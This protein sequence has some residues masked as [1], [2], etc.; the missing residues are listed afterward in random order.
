LLAAACVLLA[1][2]CAF[3]VTAC[4]NTCVHCVPV[5]FD[6]QKLRPRRVLQ[7]TFLPLSTRVL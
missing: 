6:F 1:A 4:A 7:C 3:F 2:A 5:C